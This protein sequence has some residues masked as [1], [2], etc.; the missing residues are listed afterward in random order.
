MWL[1]SQLSTQCLHTAATPL[2]A[3]HCKTPYAHEISPMLPVMSTAWS[4][5]ARHC[6]TACAPSLLPSVQ[7]TVEMSER[8]PHRLLYVSRAQGMQQTSSCFLH[9]LLDRTGHKASLLVPLRSA[10]HCINDGC[11]TFTP[12][13]AVNDA[14][15]NSILGL[16]VQRP[17]HIQVKLLH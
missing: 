13:D 11:F 4:R 17:L 3:P 8:Q 7:M 12:D 5:S 9:L 14:V 1:E 16:H 2:H 15:L 10:L 6:S